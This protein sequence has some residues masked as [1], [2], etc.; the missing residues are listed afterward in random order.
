MTIYLI[1]IHIEAENYVKFLKL[2]VFLSDFLYAY[3]AQA[4]DCSFG[5]WIGKRW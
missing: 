1:M 2:F 4:N 3:H 5:D